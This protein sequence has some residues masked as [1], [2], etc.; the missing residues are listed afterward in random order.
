MMSGMPLE[1]CWAFNERW[2][3]KFYHKVASCWLFLLSHT[4]LHGSVN[5]KHDTLLQLSERKIFVP[6]V[7]LRGMKT[8]KWKKVKFKC[9][10]SDYLLEKTLFSHIPMCIVLSRLFNFG[11]NAQHFVRLR[12]QSLEMLS[13][14]VHWLFVQVFL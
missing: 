9:L 11:F 1:T 10:F 5:I 14:S 7:G 8:C 2:N 13:Y 12:Y 4:T 3:N 6:Y